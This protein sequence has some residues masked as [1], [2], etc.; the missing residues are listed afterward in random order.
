MSFSENA[1]IHGVFVERQFSFTVG[2]ESIRVRR[3]S[4]LLVAALVMGV[5]SF[6]A[7]LCGAALVGAV[8]LAVYHAEVVAH[9]VGE[10]LGML[11]LALAVTAIETALILSLMVAGGEEMAV[12]PRDSI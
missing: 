12:L 10:S 2:V 11:V 4:P 6:L 7:A 1:G 3:S 5:G 9:R 8:L